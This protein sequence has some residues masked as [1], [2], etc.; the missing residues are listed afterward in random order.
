MGYTDEEMQIFRSDP[1]KVKMVTQTP[2]FEKKGVNSA[3]NSYLP[4]PSI[5][6]RGV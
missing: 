4:L 5:P 6:P 1:E 2:E 3:L